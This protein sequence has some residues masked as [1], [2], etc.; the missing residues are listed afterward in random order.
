MVKPQATRKRKRKDFLGLKSPRF[1]AIK[2]KKASI[3]DAEYGIEP[4]AVV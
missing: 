4:L 2:S 1:Q 3:G